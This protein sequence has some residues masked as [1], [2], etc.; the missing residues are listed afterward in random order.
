MATQPFLDDLGL[1]VLV[2]MVA[3]SFFVLLAPQQ[4]FDTRLRTGAPRLYFGDFPGHALGVRRRH[5]PK[6]RQKKAAATVRRTT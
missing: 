1:S 2:L 5:A 3:F 4:L 6:S